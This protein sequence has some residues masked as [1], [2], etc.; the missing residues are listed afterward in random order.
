MKR[1]GGELAAR[2]KEIA[3]RNVNED[4]PTVKLVND[5]CTLLETEDKRFLGQMKVALRAGVQVFEAYERDTIGQRSAQLLEAV[6]RI[7]KTL[8]TYHA[9]VLSG[10]HGV[11]LAHPNE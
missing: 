11:L 6:K 9:R 10:A 7:S 4:D 1:L 5:Y 2:I 3:E 8:E